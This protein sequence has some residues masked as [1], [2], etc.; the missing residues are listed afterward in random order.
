VDLPP[1]LA[2][3]RFMRSGESFLAR[4][5]PYRGVRLVWEAQLLLLPLLALLPLWK[6][7]PL[8]YALRVNRI[9]KRH[10]AAL[11]EAESRIER[12]EGPAEMRRQLE[13]LD[14][15]RTDLEALSRKLPAHL[16]RDV[17]HWRLHVALVRAEGLDRLRRLEERAAGAGV[18]NGKAV[19]NVAGPA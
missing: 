17:Y 18:E 1:H 10:Y 3:E 9:L 13:A 7:V 19:E 15:L 16:Q 14:G 4:W 12:C 6:A 5:L 2:A 8:L 11:R